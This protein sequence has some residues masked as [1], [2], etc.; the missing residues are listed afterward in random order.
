MPTKHNK[1]RYQRE[2]KNPPKITLTGKVYLQYRDE[3]YI[4]VAKKGDL[5]LFASAE[6]LHTLRQGEY[7]S[8]GVSGYFRVDVSDGKEWRAVK[9]QD[10]FPGGEHHFS[11]S[12]CPIDT[13]DLCEEMLKSLGGRQLVRTYREHYTLVEEE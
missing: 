7:W 5:Q 1:L 4:A 10:L 11:K 12:E 3:E 8:T 2:E 6:A 9:L 13:Y